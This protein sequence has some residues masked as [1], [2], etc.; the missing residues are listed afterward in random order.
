MSTDIETEVKSFVKNF[1]SEKRYLHSLRTA[2]TAMK[3]ADKN[4]VSSEKACLA[5]MLH[6][7]GRE[8]TEAEMIEPVRLSSRGM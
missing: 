4:G 1:V 6:D 7:V 3:L 8:L 5:A 2:E